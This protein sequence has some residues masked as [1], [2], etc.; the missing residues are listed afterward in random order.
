MESGLGLPFLPDTIAVFGGGKNVAWMEA[1]WLRTKN[2]AYWGDLDTWGLA[3]LSDVRS[4][5]PTITVLMMDQDT[6]QRHKDRMVE[7][8]K[9]VDNVPE[10]LTAS[11]TE[12]F[13]KLKNTD[14]LISR[15]EQERLSP[16]YVKANLEAWIWNKLSHRLGKY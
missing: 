2:V 16:D 14:K 9:S 11:E 8:R 4:K 5:L 15:L 6:L 13:L 1:E 7:E 3:I 10:F 12:I